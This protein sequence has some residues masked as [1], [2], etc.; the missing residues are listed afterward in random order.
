MR[1]ADLAHQ[2]GYEQSYVSALE[3]GIKGPPTQ[4]FLDRLV[5]ALNLEAEEQE[6]LKEA[7]RKSQRK[8]FLPASTPANAYQ[9]C[10]ELFDELENLHPAQIQ[11]IRNVI[12]LRQQL[13]AV[14]KLEI[15]RLHRMQ[16]EGAEM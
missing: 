16:K 7:V 9:M 14:R 6:S 13:G 10:R 4:E 12:G 1:Q 8:Y 11:V 5:M 15:E 3:I 2:L